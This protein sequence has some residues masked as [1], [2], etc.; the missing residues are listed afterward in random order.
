VKGGRRQSCPSE[1]SVM[2]LAAKRYRP[3]GV[4]S[5]FATRS[6]F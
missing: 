4:L 1:Y 6:E 5:E 3:H 2:L